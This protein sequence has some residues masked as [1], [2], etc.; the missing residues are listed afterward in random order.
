[1]ES[2][3]EIFDV[4]YLEIDVYMRQPNFNLEEVPI[5]TALVLARRCVLDNIWLHATQEIHKH[6]LAKGFHGIQVEIAQEEALMLPT[7]YPVLEVYSIVG[8]RLW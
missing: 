3:L 8:Y 6:L 7:C 1:M 5:P 2:I 4:E